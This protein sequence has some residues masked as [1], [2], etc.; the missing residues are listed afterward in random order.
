MQFKSIDALTDG[1]TDTL[2][3]ALRDVLTDTLTDTWQAPNRGP[4]ICHA[5]QTA[6]NLSQS[7]HPPVQSMPLYWRAAW[8]HVTMQ[9]LWIKTTAPRIS[10]IECNFCIKLC[11]SKVWSWYHAAAHAIRYIK[12]WSVFCQTWQTESKT[13]KDV[14]YL[15]KMISHE[16]KP[17]VNRSNIF[18]WFRLWQNFVSDGRKDGQMMN[19]A[20]VADWLLADKA[21]NNL[22]VCVMLLV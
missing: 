10:I 15:L 5:K 1:S 11:S 21:T 20:I 16:N 8:T 17:E 19:N 18:C 2:A 13:G 12:L 9:C 3:D 22:P 7:T 4:D 6:A 14:H